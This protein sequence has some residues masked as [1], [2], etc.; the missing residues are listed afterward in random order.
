MFVAVGY[1]GYPGHFRS[2][3]SI[4][5]NK[6]G[7][8][9]PH[10]TSCHFIPSSRLRRICNGFFQ[11]GTTR[12]ISSMSPLTGGEGF[13]TVWGDDFHPERWLFTR[14]TPIR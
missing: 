10:L 13:A 14:T 4:E 7:K 9:V 8:W 2:D 1:A 12:F 3:G 6:P 5:E 11:I